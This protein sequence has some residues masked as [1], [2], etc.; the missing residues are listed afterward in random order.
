MLF[1]G[2]HQDERI[3]VGIAEE[4]LRR[5]IATRDLMAI[6]DVLTSLCAGIGDGCQGDVR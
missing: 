2:R 4:F 6:R 3:Q 1:I 5:V